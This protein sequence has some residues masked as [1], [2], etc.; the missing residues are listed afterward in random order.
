MSINKFTRL[1]DS[2]ANRVQ[3][4]NA[5]S[6]QHTWVQKIIYSNS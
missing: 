2:V 6:T 3:T 4:Y 1:H 5:L